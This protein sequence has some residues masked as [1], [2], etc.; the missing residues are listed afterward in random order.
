MNRT[1]IVEQLSSTVAE[2]C[3]NVRR[4]SGI[5]AVDDGWLLKPLEAM[6]T[7]EVTMASLRAG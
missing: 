6:M 1:P 3:N 4:I 7:L 2:A 5:H